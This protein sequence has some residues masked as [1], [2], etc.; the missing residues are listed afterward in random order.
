MSSGV[1]RISFLGYTYFLLS[2]P[3]WNTGRRVVSIEHDHWQCSWLHECHCHWHPFLANLLYMYP[4]MSALACPI[5]YFLPPESSLLPGW[6]VV[7]S[8]GAV[9]AWWIFSACLP[10]CPAVGL[11]CRHLI[12][13]L[14]L[15]CGPS[16][17]LPLC[18]ADIFSAKKIKK[19]VQNYCCNMCILMWGD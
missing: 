5:F 19:L 13:V 4:A 6:L 1:P 3:Y 8:G 15:S 14:H 16:M 2:C 9:H 11:Q 18:Q 12:E 10:Q 7:T 17:T